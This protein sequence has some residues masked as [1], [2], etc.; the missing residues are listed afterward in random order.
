MKRSSF[1]KSLVTL[2]AAPSVLAKVKIKDIASEPPNPVN[3]LFQ[4]L[5]LLTPNYYKEYVEKYG[6]EDFLKLY[7]QTGY[8][9]Y[10]NEEVA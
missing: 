10:K 7:N 2:I 9:Y 4:Q 8:L 1:F 6:T 5:T 3:L